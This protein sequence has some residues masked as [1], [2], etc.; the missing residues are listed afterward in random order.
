MYAI[1]PTFRQ[2]ADD[3]GILVDSQSIETCRD[4]ASPPSGRLARPFPAES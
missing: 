3:Q 1:S 2:L 4:S